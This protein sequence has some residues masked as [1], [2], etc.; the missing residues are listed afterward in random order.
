M[1]KKLLIIFGGIT[2]LA[3]IGIIAA[4]AAFTPSQTNPAFA[5]AEAWGN[6][7]A[8][9]QEEIA[10]AHEG[11][12]LRAWASANCPN[13]RVSDCIRSL[14]PPEW[15][16]FISVLYRRAV[17]EGN[18]AWDI[19]MIGSFQR[20]DGGSGICV[21][22]RVEQNDAGVWLVEEYAGWIWCGDPASRN[23]AA[24]PDAPNRAPR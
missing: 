13:G 18:R 5:A 16:D 14:F 1:N 7:A 4:T 21:Y 10:I 17:P 12:A 11:E 2:A 20:D 9:G 6:A 15:G 3:I 22:V 8:R 19:E 23:M 24:N